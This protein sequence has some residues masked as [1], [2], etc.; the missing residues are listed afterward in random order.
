MDVKIMNPFLDAG[1]SVFETMFGIGSTNKEPYLLPVDQGHPWEISGLLGVTGDYSGIVAFR[2]HKNLAYKMLELSGMGG[3]K[4]EEQEEMARQLVSEFTNIVSGNAVSNI[5]SSL[6]VSPPVTISGRNHL[7]SW[8]RNYPV[9]AI[10]FT[11]KYG[12][13][14]V[15]ICFK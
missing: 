6:T 5:T 1:L 4:G 8:P 7:I 15:D 11:T 3:L 13:Y 9:I 14:E 10:P 12:P 2:L